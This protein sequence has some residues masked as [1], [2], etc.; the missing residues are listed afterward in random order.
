M[1]EK[2]YH[3][4]AVLIDA[5][6]TQVKLIETVLDRIATYG[7]IVVKRAHGN[8][9][10]DSLKSW[11]DEIKRLAIQAEQQFD[12][13]KGKNATD[14]ALTID[15]M[16]LL[17]KDRYDCFVLVSSDSDYTPLA[18]KLREN[19]VFVIG[20]GC[21][22]TATSFRRS[23]DEFLLLENLKDSDH[24]T[25]DSFDGTQTIDNQPA[26]PQETVSTELSADNSVESD[27][28]QQLHQWYREAWMQ[29]KENSADGYV[30]LTQIV[31]KIKEAHPSFKISS[32]NFSKNS[33]YCKHF[34]DIYETKGQLNELMI[35][36]A[37]QPHKPTVP[38]PLSN[39]NDNGNIDLIH[40]HLKRAWEQFQDADGY[41][42]LSQAGGYLK[43]VKPDFDTKT[44]GYKRLLDLLKDHPQ[45]YKLK[46]NQHYKC[47]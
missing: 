42:L 20:V 31:Q 8:W 4:I 22:Q 3:N 35:R 7:R 1:S 47:P 38:T 14:I 33:T 45:K 21:E 24:V 28:I 34:T 25:P 15:A 17:H 43:R 2:E 46:G 16:D 27:G 41:A 36:I 18:I 29:Q 37:H 12:Y 23:C 5:D 9:R 32:F 30:M 39:Q 44:Y 6:N 40:N 13:V 10:K 19:G 26:F 11:E